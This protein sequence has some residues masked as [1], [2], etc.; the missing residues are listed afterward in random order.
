MKKN[1]EWLISANL[2]DYEGEW[3]IIAKESVIAHGYD[4]DKLYSE[5]DKKYPKEEILTLSVPK[6]G[7]FIP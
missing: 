4:L 3:V 5:V 1:Y 2:S 6:K 7:D